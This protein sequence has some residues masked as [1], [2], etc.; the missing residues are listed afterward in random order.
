M[1]FPK[2]KTN[3]EAQKICVICNNEKTL[4]GK[5]YGKICKNQ[6]L[7]FCSK[8]GETI[9]AENLVESSTLHG[10]AVDLHKLCWI[11]DLEAED[12]QLPDL[13]SRKIRGSHVAEERQ[14]TEL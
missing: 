12:W 14:D 11:Q 7:R 10:G 13:L 3:G 5:N 6:G 8:C 1:P 4:W 2:R 9:N